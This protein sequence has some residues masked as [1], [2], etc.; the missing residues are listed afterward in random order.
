MIDMLRVGG[1][2][3]KELLDFLEDDGVE[4]AGGGDGLEA[5][6]E[7]DSAGEE[8]L[9]AAFGDDCFEVGVVVGGGED[10]HVAELTTK[11]SRVSSGFEDSV[12]G[13][14]GADAYA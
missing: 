7:A 10:E 8:A 6:E 13:V 1:D 4:F 9:E 2:T 14:T 5:A 3:E 12:G 11:K